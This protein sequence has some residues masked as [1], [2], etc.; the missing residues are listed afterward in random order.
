MEFYCMK[1]R[2]FRNWTAL[3]NFGKVYLGAQMEL[4]GVLRLETCLRELIETLELI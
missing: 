2:E 4:E 3:A 1:H